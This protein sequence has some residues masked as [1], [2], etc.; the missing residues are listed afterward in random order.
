MAVVVQSTVPAAFLTVTV[1]PASAVPLIGEPSVSPTV[2]VAGAVASVVT[3]VGF[4]TLPT[5][6]VAVTDN[7]VPLA[8]TVAGV[9]ENVPSA[10]AVVVQ[11]VVPPAS[12]TVTVEPASAVPVMG[13]PSVGATVGAL[14]AA[15][16]TLTVVAPETF[17]LGSV[18]VTAMTAPFAGTGE[19][20]QVHEPSARA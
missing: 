2:G 14:G 19:G 7:V 13:E 12:F 5:A 20:V 8:G 6:S 4:D 17:P 16:S 18:D 9:H 15:E 11:I 3:G 10:V 1:V